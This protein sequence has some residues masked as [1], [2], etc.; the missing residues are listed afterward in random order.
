[1]E[2]L[3]NKEEVYSLEKLKM[4]SDGQ[5]HSHTTASI[6]YI[7]PETLLATHRL[8]LPPKKNPPTN[9]MLNHYNTHPRQCGVWNSPGRAA[10]QQWRT[11]P[12]QSLSAWPLLHSHSRSTLLPHIVT[13]TERSLPPPSIRST[14]FL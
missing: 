5:V 11:A 4:S 9:W 13:S 2:L 1:M 7:Y 8:T 6:L 10:P 14:C 12:H 3:N